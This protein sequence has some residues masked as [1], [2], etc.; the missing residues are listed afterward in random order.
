MRKPPLCGQVSYADGVV[1]EISLN[2]T[3]YASGSDMW[4]RDVGIIVSIALQHNIPLAALRNAIGRDS[5]G[6]PTSPIGTVLDLIV[7]GNV[8]N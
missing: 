6:Q 5:D 3:R 7:K 8:G 1:K 4:A 2:N